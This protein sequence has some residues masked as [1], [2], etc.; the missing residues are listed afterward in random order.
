MKKIILN[1][2][3]IVSIAFF[4]S[5]AKDKKEPQQS[6]EEVKN[7]VVSNKTD[8]DKTEVSS[9]VNFTEE[10]VNKVYAQ[11]LLVKKGLVNSDAAAVQKA[12]KELTSL[13]ED[14][15]ET[16]NLKATAELISITKGID[17]QRDFFV[18]LTNETEKMIT[19][20][21][22]TTGKVYKQYCPMAFDNTGGYWLSDSKEIR[23]PY[24]GD[25]MLKCGKVEEEIK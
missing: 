2:V 19:N 9:V 15:E 7:E 18:A 3:L 23:N 12:S 11:Y 13:L 25:R 14:G 21:D 6:N 5:C 4:M 16:K 17:K 10:S 20:A 24:F 1:T 22:I 8:L